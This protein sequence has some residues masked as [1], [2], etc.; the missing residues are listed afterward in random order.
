MKLIILFSFLIGRFTC[1]AQI[2]IKEG[3]TLIVSKSTFATN[4]SL[5]NR[6]TL[7]SDDESILTLNGTGTLSTI[8]DFEIGTFNYS[9]TYQ[10]LG[11]I[12]ISK[13][14]N[15]QKG[16]LSPTVDAHLIAGRDAEVI[17]TNEAHINGRFY[18]EGVGKKYFPVG[19][20]GI[21]TPVRLTDVS[22]GP[23][24]VVGL[25]AHN[26][27]LGI[28]DFPQGIDG[29][30]PGWF[31]EITSIGTFHGSVIQLP[32]TEEDKNMVED[33]EDFSVLQ[34]NRDG[35]EIV[36]IGGN[37]HLGLHHVYSSIPTTGPI[38]ILA[39][40]EK[41]VPII[42]NI[43]TPNEDGKNDRLF[44]ENIELFGSENLVILLDRWGTEVC[45]IENFNNHP[46][47]QNRCK[48]D[49]L[50][51]GNYTC[52]VQSGAKKMPPTMITILK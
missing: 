22:G 5:I 19:K 32:I 41:N 35:I 12:K 48:I 18:H 29:A 42:H 8:N 2:H 3:T 34:T 47:P 21:K 39:Y 45:R 44:I 7:K 30:S 51:A 43:I 38:I 9:G 4:T 14:L 17:S 1:F 28:S 11:R 46:S 16:T 23:D 6:G 26:E 24:V 33:F 36:E 49:Q 25:E 40:K 15:L 20:N 52:I 13:R 37:Y 10:L 50:P 27:D 31:W